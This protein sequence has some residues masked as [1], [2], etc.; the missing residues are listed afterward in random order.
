MVGGNLVISSLETITIS[1][2]KSDN[3]VSTVSGNQIIQIIQSGNQIIQIIQ[4]NQIIQSQQSRT[5]SEEQINAR[6]TD[7]MDF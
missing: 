1:L 5:I 6:K 3:P 7:Y 2:R 4:I